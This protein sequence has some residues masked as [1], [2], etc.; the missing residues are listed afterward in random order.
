[1]VFLADFKGLNHFSRPF[2][3]PFSKM[4]SIPEEDEVEEPK[5][6]F[7]NKSLTDL[8]D[9]DNDNDNDNLDEIYKIIDLPEDEVPPPV[10]GSSSPQKTKKSPPQ[11]PDPMPLFLEGAPPLTSKKLKRRKRKKGKKLLKTVEN[12]GSEIVL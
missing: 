6:D 1:M 5:N 7:V 2:F 12:E 10:V 4:E 9:N 3:E 8:S 11:I